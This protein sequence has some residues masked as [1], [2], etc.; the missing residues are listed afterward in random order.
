MEFTNSVEICSLRVFCYIR[1][2]YRPHYDKSPRLK[3]G[4]LRNSEYISQ[5]ILK[6]F[7]YYVTQVAKTI[8]CVFHAKSSGL[9][10]RN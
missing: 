10:L 2:T 4:K 9:R 8:W 3:K 7:Y 6:Q 1:R 5:N